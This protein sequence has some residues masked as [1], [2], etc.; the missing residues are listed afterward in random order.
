MKEKELMNLPSENLRPWAREGL[1]PAI[2][3][4]AFL[5]ISNYAMDL[6]LDW[7]GIPGSKTLINDLVIGALGAVA[8]VYYLAASRAKHNFENA[9]ERIVLIGELNQRIRNTLT[10]ASSSAMSDDPRERLRGLDYAMSNIDAILF[11]FLTTEI[12]PN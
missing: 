2:I 6:A 10:M 5:C 4:G 11:D 3:T 8:V 12:Q 7:Y 9:K 1:A